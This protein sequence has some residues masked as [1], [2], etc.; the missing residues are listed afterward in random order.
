MIKRLLPI[1]ALLLAPACFA[2]NTCT[3]TATGSNWSS[4]THWTCTPAGTVPGNGDTAIISNNTTV[5]VN[6]TVGQSGPS[7]V[8]ATGVYPQSTL[9]QSAGGGSLPAGAYRANFTNVDSGGKESAQAYES[10]AFTL[11][12]TDTLIVTMPA[13]PAGV[14][15]RNI[16]LTAA[17]GAAGTET[18]YATGVTTT[19]YNATSASWDNGT[20]T[21]ALAAPLPVNNWAIQITGGNLTLATGVTFTVHGDVRQGN[22]G[23]VLDCGS[24]WEY[25]ASTSAGTTGNSYYDMAGVAYS[26]PNGTWTSSGSCSGSPW[27]IT[28]NTGGGPW[29]LIT[30]VTTGYGNAG[31]NLAYGNISNCGSTTSVCWVLSN[32]TG[33]NGSIVLDHVI[34]NNV[35]AIYELNIPLASNLSITNVSFESSSP[36]YYSA[37][38]AY[39]VLYIG[40][41]SGTP[42]GT[43]VFT[44]NV[45]DREAYL[46]A[47][48]AWT[49]GNNY[50][51]QG[52]LDASTSS[53]I[54][55][56]NS[57]IRTPTGGSGSNNAM[58][59]N[60]GNVTNSYFLEDYWPVATVSSTATSA[61]GST[62][63]DST[64][65]WTTN[66]YQASSSVG[67][68]VLITGG[69]GAGQ[70]RSIA[71]NTATS[72]TVTLNWT[73][74]PDA[75]S[76]Y[77][78][79][80][81]IGHFHQF[82][83]KTG[84]HTGDIFDFTTVEASSNNGECFL[85]NAVTSVAFETS[86][87]LADGSG[88]DTACSLINFGSSTSSAITVLHNT[89][90]VGS[91]SPFVGDYTG[92]AGMIASYENNLFWTFSSTASVTDGPLK[93][94]DSGHPTTGGVQNYVSPTNA[95]Y[96]ACWNCEAGGYSGNG[97]S[98]NLTAQAG[99][100]DVNLSGSTSASGPNFVDPTRDFLAWCKSLG[101]TGTVP[102]IISTCRANMMTQ[103]NFSGVVSGFTISALIS[104]V[105]AGFAPQNSALHNTASDGTDIGAV[106][107]QASGSVR[108]R[109]SVIN[110]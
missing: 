52:W 29:G 22:Y 88:L 102:S 67:W 53:T 76:T 6:T 39:L 12:S 108:H 48:S 27:A 79:Y 85:Q 16:Y 58:V 68:F 1:L 28:A 70:M 60:A 14:S 109:A 104:W 49:W 103:N 57:F 38:P 105:T 110:Q 65:S 30:N 86:I 84:T 47:Q 98:I 56:N 74:T 82:S 44:G 64:E 50:F 99:A 25:D 81:G 24:T 17:A 63:V 13:L 75:T 37:L 51:D 95:D 15:S 90:M 23:V 93:L 71:S 31:M 100:H 55:F 9:S 8:L 89:A 94:L 54:A 92:I 35:G 11:T 40:D 77:S 2:G 20:T 21:Q 62:L 3:T 73:T 45:F 5:D 41:A 46:K 83:T 107:Y 36:T 80:Q 101:I 96:N 32:N 4:S 7:I 34:F 33:S 66:A 72:L 18:L 10:G 91:E 78:I 19:M 43:R 26:Q 106:A 42:T 69:T 97:Y 61:T 87:V 59:T